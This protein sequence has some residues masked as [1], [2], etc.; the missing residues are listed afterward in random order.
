M[1]Y[2]RAYDEARSDEAAFD[3]TEND[4]APGDK[5]ASERA[6][7]GSDVETIKNVE[8]ESTK[9]AGSLEEQ[10]KSLSDSEKDSEKDSEYT[11]DEEIEVKSTGEGSL[12]CD[13]NEAEASQLESLITV[14]SVE[15]IA[16][17]E[18][19]EAENSTS[20]TRATVKESS[21][22]STSSSSSLYNERHASVTS[23]SFSIFDRLSELF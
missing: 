18:Y 13:E 4:S 11:R 15:D 20:Y 14:D 19:Y 21:A 16:D 23:V 7:S 6:E 8:T 3:S 22:Q 2:K 17:S 9:S 12:I 10:R 5:A 1:S